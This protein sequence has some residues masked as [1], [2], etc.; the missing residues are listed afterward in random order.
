MLRM[1]SIKDFHNFD[2]KLVSFV[3][4]RLFIPYYMV[5]PSKIPYFEFYLLQV[6]FLMS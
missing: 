3:S 6:E 4:I 1:V 5:T 2:D